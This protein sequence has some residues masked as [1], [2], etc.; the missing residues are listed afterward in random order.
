ME[1]PDKE[2]ATARAGGRGRAEA[3]TSEA[4]RQRFRNRAS[5]LRPG[6]RARVS[7]QR[8]GGLALHALKDVVPVLRALRRIAAE[9]EVS[10]A[11]RQ[12]LDAPREFVARFV[13]I[14][15]SDHGGPARQ[16][17]EELLE[18]LDLRGARRAGRAEIARVLAP[19]ATELMVAER[20]DR[21]LGD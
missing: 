16:S 20:I 11:A 6:A 19:A 5:S 13:G 9:L 2:G 14:D 17:R 7:R 21:A 18:Q 1:A 4:E 3:R 15:G 10:H 8:P 12:R